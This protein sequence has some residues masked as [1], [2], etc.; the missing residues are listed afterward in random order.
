MRALLL[1]GVAG[2]LAPGAAIGI[3]PYSL[4]LRRSAVPRRAVPVADESAS[5]AATAGEPDPPP[6]VGFG[7][8][9]RGSLFRLES[10]YAEARARAADDLRSKWSSQRVAEA[11]VAGKTAGAALAAVVVCESILFG[12][13]MLG[14][15]ALGLGDPSAAS[16]RLASAVGARLGG[17]MASA[18]ALRR[19]SRPA[20]LGLEA[21]VAPLVYRRAA[22][23]AAPLVAM[24]EVA[25]QCV[26]VVA[27]AVVTLRALDRGALATLALPPLASL[28][29]PLHAAALDALGAA[30]GYGA[31]A[32]AAAN[33]VAPLRLLLSFWGWLAAAED[34]AA[35]AALLLWQRVLGPMLRVVRDLYMDS[36]LRIVLRNVR[37]VLFQ[38]LLG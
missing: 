10:N 31:A 14:A 28:A 23:S 16:P 15:W 36:W 38:T 12:A 6:S 27:C 20:R 24:R 1:L 30:Q 8:G 3:A 22:R 21:V 35:A 4:G 29:P 11:S 33:G 18:A 5:H 25:V 7:T 26:A 13:A 2:I 9:F 37:G 34:W 19:A 17:A 32:L